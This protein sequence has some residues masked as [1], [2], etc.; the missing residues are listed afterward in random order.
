MILDIANQMNKSQQIIL[1]G[2][3]NI[4]R[5]EDSGHGKPEQRN[6]YVKKLEIIVEKQ[7]K[8]G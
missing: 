7:K 3:K 2:L 6:N 8:N 4:L 5:A 1:Y